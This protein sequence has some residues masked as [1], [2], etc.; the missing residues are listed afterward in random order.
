L[1]DF[2][3][4]IL[5]RRMKTLSFHDLW[6]SY[7]SPD[8]GGS[9]G[10]TSIQDNE[11]ATRVSIALQNSGFWEGEQLDK[12]V[13]YYQNTLQAGYIRPSA[14]SNLSGELTGG[15]DRHLFRGA[16]PLA[17][18]IDF[19]VGQSLWLQAGHREVFKPITSPAP[20]ATRWSALQERLTAC[21]GIIFFKDY[22]PRTGESS[23]F[24]G[25]HIDLWNCGLMRIGSNEEK[26]SFTKN[27]ELQSTEVWFWRIL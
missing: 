18:L 3:R 12:L 10:Y 13:S 15:V 17:H 11:C 19:A 7:P 8:D 20:N 26:F 6:Q 21:N 4:F 1:T 23:S 25:D 5:S 9:S 14:K 2:V 22:W 24:T 27:A 16:E